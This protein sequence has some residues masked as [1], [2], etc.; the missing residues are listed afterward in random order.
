MDPAPG[1]EI[2][3]NEPGTCVCS[4]R[5]ALSLCR[6]VAPTAAP[7]KASVPPGYKAVERNG[8]TLYC[9]RVASLGTKFKPEVCMTQ[10]EYDE[11]Q[12]RGENARQELR[13]STTICAG[14]SGVSS[15]NG[16]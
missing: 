3:P 15:C 1:L 9:T 13:K 14:G 16:S 5:P 8:T 4:P 2:L 7:G 6:R 11:V 12:R 10:D